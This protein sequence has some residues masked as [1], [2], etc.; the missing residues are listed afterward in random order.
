MRKVDIEQRSYEWHQQR[1]GN[2]T[3]TSLGRALGK[4][5]VQETLMY[6]LVAQRMTRVQIDDLSNASMDRGREL[7]PFARTEVTRA[8]GITFIDTGLL[9]SDQFSHFSISPDGIFEDEQGVIT[10]G[11][12]LKCPASKT[13]VRY[14]MEDD[15]P[16]EYLAQVMAPFIMSDDVMFWCFASFDDRNHERPLFIKTVTR[17]DFPDI[18]GDRLKLRRFLIMVAEHHSNLSIAF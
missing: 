12:E 16:S 9:V 10:G 7:E 18:K 5:K 14:I 11:L 8:T 4:P 1:W 17:D 2:V 3:G 15:I 13:H 6:E